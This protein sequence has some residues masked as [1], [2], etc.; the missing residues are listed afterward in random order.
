[1]S[2]SLGSLFPEHAREDFVVRAIKPGAVLRIHVDTT[3]PPKTKRL[4]VLA[5]SDN[6]ICVGYLFIN[7]EINPNVNWNASLQA[8][9]LPLDAGSNEYLDHD[10]YLDCSSIHDMTFDDLKNII[11]NDPALHIGTIGDADLGAAT[12]KVTGAQTISPSQKRRYNLI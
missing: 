5:I 4:V 6:K 11:T 3:T 8:L 9:H 10:S 12:E 7:S 2:P 1:M